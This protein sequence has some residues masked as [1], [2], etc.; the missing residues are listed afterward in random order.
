MSPTPARRLAAAVPGLALALAAFAGSPDARAEVT[1]VGQPTGSLS[2]KRIVI[3]PGHGLY[4]HETYGWLFQRDPINGLHEDLHCNEL[5]MDYVRAALEGAGARV[6]ATRSPGRQTV[7]VIVD[8][9]GP[10]YREEGS[11]TTTTNV[12]LGWKGSYRYAATSRERAT[13]T[14]HFSATLPERGDYPV[15]VFYYA[16]ADRSARAA[17]TIRHA[18]GET[19]ALVN[20]KLDRSRWVY[21][22]TYPFSPD[23][24]AEVTLD[25]YDPTAATGSESVIISDAVRFGVG[26]GDVVHNGKPSGAPRWHEESYYYML[27]HGAPESVYKTRATERDSGLVS[28]AL[29]ADWQG[30]DAFVSIH[31]NA[32]EMPNVGTGVS[33]YVHDTNPSPGSV[34]MQSAIHAELLRTTQKLYVPSFRDRGK[35]SANFAVVRETRTMP[36]VLLE[37]A[38][39][40]TATPD[41]QLLRDDRYRRDIARA[42]YKGLARYFDKTAP[43]TPLAPTLL[44]AENLGEG[45]VRLRFRPESDPLEPGAAAERYR[46]FVQRG[47]SAFGNPVEVSATEHIVEGLV[48]GETYYFKVRAVNGGGESLPSSALGV[49]IVGPGKVH[50][51]VL[52]VDGFQ[53]LDD[54]ITYRSGDQ[55]GEWVIAH[56][57]ALAGSGHALGSF[58]SVHRLALTTAAVVD[59]AAYPILDLLLGAETGS[60]VLS[61]RELDS[62]RQLL[63][64]SARL[65]VSGSDV[66][67]SLGLR[68]TPATQAFFREVLSVKCAAEYSGAATLSGSGNLAPLGRLAFTE[69]QRKAGARSYPVVAPDILQPEARAEVLLSYADGSAAAVVAPAQSPGPP[70]SGARAIVLGLPFESIGT[71]DA[72]RDT[73]MGKLLDRLCPTAD[74]CPAES[75][76]VLPTEMPQKPYMP[77]DGAEATGCKLAPRGGFSV[78]ALALLLVA[79]LGLLLSSRRRR[80]VR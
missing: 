26:M 67:G 42:I 74:A 70:G 40:D 72:E 11:F 13:A 17:Y 31:T 28:R 49:R 45:R 14:A 46:I 50:P 43:L 80:R 54:T 39:H 78:A 52:I 2:G 51:P 71:S 10:G 33:S 75:R 79:P 62:L 8:N 25:N 68:G 21:L 65:I 18:G 3:D 59:L 47:N 20:Q 35:L 1:I 4:W 64:R 30:G 53:R 29:Y 61:E 22:G 23:L 32:A 15:W 37:L 5:V 41:A 27:D 63:G 66:L 36:A 77:G 34:S 38:F 19:R 55:K 57:Q 9:D 73:L 44:A 24:P 16:G 6:L 12:G 60:S 56:G 7:S 76:P 58:D 69:A 48:P